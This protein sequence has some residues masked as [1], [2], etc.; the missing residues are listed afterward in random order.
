[1]QERIY[2]VGPNGG[3]LDSVKVDNFTGDDDRS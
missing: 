2:V 1:M 3:K